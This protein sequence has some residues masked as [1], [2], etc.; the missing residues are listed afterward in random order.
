[1]IQCLIGIQPRLDEHVLQTYGLVRGE[2][3][4]ATIHRQ[5]N[6]DSQARMK[7]IVDAILSHRGTVVLPLHPRTAK[8]LRA[9]NMFSGLESAKRVQI[10]PPLNFMAFA[11]LERY[12]RVIMTD[13]GGVQKEAYFFGVPCVT[14]REE[15]E[16]EETVAEGWNT[17]VGTDTAKILDALAFP[18]PGGPRKTS[19]GDVDV[20]KRIVKCIEGKGLG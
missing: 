5:E 13:S 1:M 19:Y 14:I 11:A 18:R 20:A 10:L 15:T 7:S 12:A 17:L 8:N 3:V 16:W 6:A 4:L 2:Y 9:W